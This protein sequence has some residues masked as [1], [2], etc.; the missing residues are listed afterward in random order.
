M[1]TAALNGN[2][3]SIFASQ[4]TPKILY[5]PNT[6]RT[7]EIITRANRTFAMFGFMRDWADQLD[8][9]STY[10]LEHYSPDSPLV[11]QLRSATGTLLTSSQ[12][13]PIDRAMLQEVYDLLDPY[14]PGNVWE[15]VRGVRDG[16]RAV[17]NLIGVVDW[18]LFYPMESEAD[19]IKVSG[20][21]AR[22]K[23]L[24]MSSVFA[25]VVFN[26][27]IERQDQLKRVSIKIRMNSSYVHV[28]DDYK[29]P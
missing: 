25:V 16:A 15:L 18:D 27:D 8:N 14:Q 3:S 22:R 13:L 1:S 28:T 19:M 20:S 5:S 17:K 23:E 4:V 29:E 24:G 9:C 2:Y 7:R 12:F 26:E 6:A 10:F 21:V 11:V